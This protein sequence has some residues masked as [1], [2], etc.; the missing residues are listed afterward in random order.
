MSAGTDKDI[1][2]LKAQVEAL[3]AD[4]AGISDA[5]KNLG[6]DAA[7]E[8]R[9][10]IRRAAEQARG[11]ARD[12]IGALENEIEDRPLT[13]LLTA[14]GIGFVLGKLLDR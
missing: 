7:S 5:L 6:G 2:E 14:F 12:T 10:R 11:K 9:E 13:S 1:E 8:G 3:R 4:L